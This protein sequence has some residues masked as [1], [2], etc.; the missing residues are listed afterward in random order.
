MTLLNEAKSQ[1]DDD[2]AIR[3]SREMDFLNGRRTVMG[4]ITFRSN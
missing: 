2:G 3:H 1:F 4:E